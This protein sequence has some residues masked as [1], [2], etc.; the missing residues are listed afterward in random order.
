M[1]DVFILKRLESVDKEL[2]SIINELRAKKSTKSLKEIRDL[3]GR[4][5]KSEEDPTAIVRQMRSKRYDL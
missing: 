3:F 4:S 5:I 2:H 1:E